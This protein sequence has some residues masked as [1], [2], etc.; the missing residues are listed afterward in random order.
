MLI[1]HLNGLPHQAKV[2]KMDN[3]INATNSTRSTY[4]QIAHG[5]SAKID[6]LISDSWVGE[7]ERQLLDRFLETIAVSS[8]NVLD[9]GCG[10][11]K[12][13]SYL[14]EQ[15]A[16]P[17]G[18][19]ISSGMLEAARKHVAEGILLQMDMR[20]LGFSDELFDGVWANGCI[21]HVPKT[22]FV[23]V[24]KEI[25]RVL[26]PKGVFSFTAKAGA[27]EK[28]EDSPRSYGGGPRFYAYY[29]IREIRGYLGRAGFEVLETAEYPQRIFGERLLHISARKPRRG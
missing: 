19:D 1:C 18:I 7:F 16:A 20:A 14:G 6:K 21:Y 8:P 24:L 10:N 25:L 4:D 11:G 12:D 26:K 29:S 28:L 13:T 3:T 2:L 27:G 5:Y 15:G 9:I 17:L 23:Q 22:D